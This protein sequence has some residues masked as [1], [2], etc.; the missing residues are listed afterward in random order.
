MITSRNIPL[1]PFVV[2]AL[3]SRTALA[4]ELD[5]LQFRVG[6]SVQ[7]DS[8]IFRLS[9]SAN[10]QALLG[11]AD[12]SDTIG[13]TSVGVKLNKSYSLQ[14]F[15]LDASSESYRYKNFSN[16]NFNAIN[17]AAAWR[18]SVTPAFHGNLTSEQREYVDNTADIQNTGK[19]NRRTTRSNLADAE[20]EVDGTWR[21]VGGV[22]ERTS[23]NSQPFTFEGDSKI[24]GAEA[25]LRHV[26]PSGTSVAYRFRNGNGSYTNRLASPDIPAAFKDR[27]HEVRL[28]WVPTGKTTVQALASRFE[29]VHDGFPARDFSGVIG[30]LN[31]TWAVTGKTSITAGLARE[32]GSYQASTASYFQGRRLFIAPTWKPTEKTAVRLRYDHAVRDYRG[33]LPG[34]PASNRQDT[35]NIASLAVEWQPIRALKLTASVQRDNRSSSQTGFDYKSNAVN[36]LAQVSF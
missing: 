22:F 17:Y 34:L 11:R 31:T 21:A 6:Q 16:L 2:L 5:T 28:D 19:L 10:T 29:R 35:I 32:L 24:R 26:S 20:Y 8:N 33:P 25:G 14:R 23:V 3:F 12:R 7:H 1:I 18:W 15:E 4:D 9:E 30:Q 27:E 36:L 13:V